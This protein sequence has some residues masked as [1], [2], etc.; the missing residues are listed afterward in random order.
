[1]KSQRPAPDRL[2][3]GP[4]RRLATPSIRRRRGDL[5]FASMQ[6]PP[7][8]FCFDAKTNTGARGECG[9]P[10]L[11]LCYVVYC[12][13]RSVVYRLVPSRGW[14]AFPS[15][16]LTGCCPS[17]VP[18]PLP[19]PLRS[20]RLILGIYVSPPAI[21]GV[22]L[23]ARSS[24]ADWPNHHGGQWMASR[25]R[26]QPKRYMSLFCLSPVDFAGFGGGSGPILS[27]GREGRHST[28]M[29]AHKTKTLTLG[30][31]VDQR[32]VQVPQQFHHRSHV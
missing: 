4:V 18:P 21:R 3:A 5:T 6:S 32:D 8:F 11:G 14:V 30:H 2:S 24:P 1:M 27:R 28:Q 22:R 23:S 17:F 13:G 15:T 16:H 26:S 25:A 10:E 7:V 29:S 19:P 31:L 20:R 12:I 9:G